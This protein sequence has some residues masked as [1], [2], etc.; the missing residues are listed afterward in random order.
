MDRHVHLALKNH[1][2]KTTRGS[3]TRALLVTFVHYAP[4]RFAPRFVAGMILPHA[5]QPPTRALCPV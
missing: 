2:T 1:Y 4:L 3:V 5:L